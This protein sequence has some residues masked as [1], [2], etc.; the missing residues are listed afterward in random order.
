MS[1][2]HLER[3]LSVQ[4]AKGRFN[5]NIVPKVTMALIMEAGMIAFHKGYYGAKEWDEISQDAG[6]ARHEGNE[7]IGRITES[8][9]TDISNIRR[10][11]ENIMTTSDFP[12]ALSMI[13]DRARRDSYFPVESPIL[14]FARKRTANDFKRMRGVRTDVFDRLIKRPEGTTVK[15]VSFGSTEDGYQIANYELALGFTW[16]SYINDDIGEFIAASAALGVA[17]RRTRQY[18]TL[19]AIRSQVARELIGGSVGGPDSDRLIALFDAFSSQTTTVNLPDGT[20]ATKPMPMLL[21]DIIIPIKWTITANN[22]LQS[23][24]IAYGGS[25]AK[26]SRNP[27]QGLAVATV[28][29][30]MGE[31]DNP[32]DWLGIDNRQQWLEFAALRGYEAG[33]KTFTK[34]PDVMETMDEGTFA[35]HTFDIKISDN[36]GA[37]VTNVKAVKRVQ[38]A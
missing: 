10:I 38:G 30:M 37:L 18:I 26:M 11:R 7:F 32:S 8:L 29:P 17:A 9:V 34:L 6:K 14:A 15:Y 23:T 20:T 31:F 21:S 22:A 16:E 24:N 35:N 12:L 25:V 4:A 13:R 3:T 5:E 19:E 2:R 27:S 1:I 33:P 36:V 28:D